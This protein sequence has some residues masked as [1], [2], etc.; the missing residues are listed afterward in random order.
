MILQFFKQFHNKVITFSKYFP[1]LKI[2][3]VLTEDEKFKK[4]MTEKFMVMFKEAGIPITKEKIEENLDFEKLIHIK[5]NPRRHEHHDPYSREL[6]V[7]KIILSDFFVDALFDLGIDNNNSIDKGGII[8]FD[9]NLDIFFVNFKLTFRTIRPNKELLQ[10]IVVF[11]KRLKPILLNI[12]YGNEDR[13]QKKENIMSLSDEFFL[14]RCHYLIEESVV[15]E[16]LPEFQID[17]VYD[18][19]SEEFKNKIEYL[20]LLEY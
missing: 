12:Q 7:G 9:K 14:I 19:N 17:G 8:L 13:I 18:Y 10:F 3:S 20:K 5:K 15:N 1:L 16:L 4:E 2:K 11:D 6:G